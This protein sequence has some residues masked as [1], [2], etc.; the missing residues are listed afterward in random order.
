[1]SLTDARGFMFDLD[2]TLVARAADGTVAALPGAAAVIEAIRASDRPL[3]IFTN[4]SHTGP[5]N[6]AR[7]ARDA[8][9]AVSDAEVLTAACSALGHLGRRHLG[10]QVMLLATAS[11][12]ERFAAAG[13]D[14]VALGEA[15]RADVVLTLHVDEIAMAE[16]EAAAHAVLAGAS[17]LTANYQRAYAGRDGPIISRGAMVAA[18]IAKASGRRPTVVGKPSAAAVAEIAERLGVAP[19]EVAYIGDDLEMDVRLGKLAGGTTVLV[20]TGISG[21]P[22]QPL[23]AQQSPDRALD[24]VG[25]LLGL[26]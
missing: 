26:L 12:R 18:A 15:E 13:V 16:L 11:A 1:M 25:D 23:P 10:A 9:L 7:H 2:G 22:M 4:A 8:G 14:V 19:G 20:R 6:I 3:V 24:G 5:A 21:T 17:F